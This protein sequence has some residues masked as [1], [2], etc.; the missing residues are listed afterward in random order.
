MDLR[1]CVIFYQ[2]QRDGQARE[3]S[4]MGEEIM[5]PLITLKLPILLENDRRFLQLDRVYKDKAKA[6]CSLSWRVLSGVEG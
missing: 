5:R 4:D 6:L 3:D 2:L 1:I